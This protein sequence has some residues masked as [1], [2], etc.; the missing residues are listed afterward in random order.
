MG[1]TTSSIEAIHYETVVY[2]S[3]I[4]YAHNNGSYPKF[5]Y[6]Q[7]KRI[8]ISMNMTGKILSI[9][10]LTDKETPEN[11]E[12][13]LNDNKKVRNKRVITLNDTII[14]KIIKYIES[15]AILDTLADDISQG[16]SLEEPIIT[17]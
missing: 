17:Q 14:S 11:H 15:K 8:I 1:S 9:R 2:N 6:I 13:Y 5:I 16:I 7:S 4:D 10:Y 12:R 3:A